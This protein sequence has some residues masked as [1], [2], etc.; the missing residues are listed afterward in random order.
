MT[1]ER[2]VPA[3]RSAWLAARGRDVTASQIGALFGEHEYMT[4]FSLWGLKTGRIPREEEET[5]AMQRGRLPPHRGP[6]VR[7]GRLRLRPVGAQVAGLAVE[8]RRRAR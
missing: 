6:R 1:V 4:P 5:P 8:Q 7:P 2:I 3:N